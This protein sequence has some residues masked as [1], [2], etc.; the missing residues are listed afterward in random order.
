MNPNDIDIIRLLL[1]GK[2]PTIAD[3]M[4]SA[5]GREVV[6]VLQSI[7]VAERPYRALPTLYRLLRQSEVEQIGLAPAA[8]TPRRAL[9]S[10]AELYTLPP[11]RWLIDGEIPDQSLMVLYGDSGAGKSFVALD[12]ALRLANNGRVVLYVATEGLRGY[13]KRSAAWAAYHGC[14]VPSKLL[15]Y[16]DRFNLMDAGALA[17]LAD[18]LKTVAPALIVVDTLAMSMI[19]ADENSSRDMGHALNGCRRL[20]DSLGAT[21]LLVHHSGKASAWERGSSALRGNADVMMRLSAADD[22]IQMECTKAKDF[23]PPPPRYIQLR[24][25]GDSLVPVQINDVEGTRKRLTNIQ[26]RVLDAL[27]METCRDG[28]SLRE[29]A[30]IL[31][32]A[33]STLHRAVSNA[34]QLEL[35]SKGKSGYRITERGRL[36]QR[37]PQHARITLSE[38]NAQNTSI[39]AAKTAQTGAVFGGD[40]VIRVIH[41]SQQTTLPVDQPDQR[42]NRYYHE[43]L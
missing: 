29:L 28:V 18:H 25:H 30:E 14:R 7:P 24:E 43:G 34:I 9:V 13:S 41:R 5:R 15:F 3:Y 8:S 35:V 2:D 38:E 31:G 10:A 33:Y 42:I 19:G 22:V 32:V 23:D 20:I 21:V 1:Q 16:T 6:S 11:I 36:I 4:L 37:D 39:E 27:V 40:P 17:T 12:Y 26:R